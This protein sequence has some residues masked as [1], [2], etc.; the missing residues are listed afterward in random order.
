MWWTPGGAL[1]PDSHLTSNSLQQLISGPNVHQVSAASHVTM[2]GRYV[3]DPLVELSSQ[4][5]ILPQTPCNSFSLVHIYIRSSSYLKLPATTY[6]W[7][8]LH[9]VS[10][11]SL[12]TMSGRYVVDLLEELSS[13]T[14]ILHQTPCYSFSQ[15]HTFIR[16]VQLAT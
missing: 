3:V 12:V 2:S 15:V 14:V 16:S 6:L 7:S 10:A 11:A 8:N 5:V 1:L 9:Q 13:Q 4:T